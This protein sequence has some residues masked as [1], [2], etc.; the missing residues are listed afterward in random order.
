MIRNAAGLH[1]GASD[2]TT[3]TSRSPPPLQLGAAFQTS[4]GDPSGLTALHE[5]RALTDDEFN[6]D[7]A[8]LLE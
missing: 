8:K 1:D 6:T 5:V 7:N 2:R 3:A 4:E